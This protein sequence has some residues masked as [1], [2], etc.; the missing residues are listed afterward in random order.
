MKKK[1][2]NNSRPALRLTALVVCAMLWLSSAGNMACFATA[3]SN[4]SVYDEPAGTENAL[5]DDSLLFAEEISA[6]D[7]ADD[8]TNESAADFTDGPSDDNAALPDTPGGAEAQE[9][10][11]SQEDMFDEEA[12]LTDPEDEWILEEYAVGEEQVADEEGTDLLIEDPDAAKGESAETDDDSSQEGDL[13]S[14]DDPM[15]EEFVIDEPLVVE[16]TGNAGLLRGAK[17]LLGASSDASG[18]F[19]CYGD[20]LG[21][22]ARRIY[23]FRKQ[24]YVT[25]R[26]VGTLMYNTDGTPTDPRKFQCED[27]TFTKDT[28]ICTFTVPLNSE[29]Q[30]DKSSEE[31]LTAYSNILSICQSATDAYQYD[32][33]EM[34]WT[35]KAEY[36]V[37]YAYVASAYTLEDGTKVRDVY[38]KGLTYKALEAYPNAADTIAAYDQAVAQTAESIRSTSDFDGNGEVSDN[39][40][41]QGIHDYICERCWYDSAT[42]A[43]YKIN[44]DNGFVD[45]N[46]FTSAGVFLDSVSPGIVCEGYSRGFKVLCDYFGIRCACIGG[47]VTTSSDMGHMWNNV[48]LNGIWYMVDVTWDDSSSGWNWKL[49]LS[50]TDGKRTPKGYLSGPTSSQYISYTVG[51]STTRIKVSFTSVLFSLPQL[52]SDT[53]DYHILNPQQSSCTGYKEYVCGNDDAICYWVKDSS[54]A[55][56]P[57]HTWKSERTVDREP[58][59]EEA[60]IRAI[61]CE[62][63]NA[64]KR[65]SQE[66]IAAPGHDLN[67]V[68][69]KTATCEND[70]NEAY[71]KC[72]RCGKLFADENGLQETDSEA[73]T[74]HAPGHDL[75]FAEA[76]AAT[77]ENDGNEAYWRCERC[78]K[79]FADENG[80]QET[81]SETVT[82]HAPGHDLTFAEAKV[83]TCENDGN[84]AYWRCE[85][86]G[87]LFADENS[88][89][90]TDNESVKIPALGH[91]LKLV[92]AKAAT[93]E[94][95][96]IK[97][98]WKCERCGKLFA[99]ENG[100]QETDSEAVVIPALG[101][102]WDGGVITTPATSSKTGVRTYTC[103]R[104]GKT[105]TEE[106]P[107]DEKQEET[108]DPDA[109]N[110]KAA[111]E[112]EKIIK[113]KRDDT[114]LPGSAFGVLRA[115]VKK[116]RKTSVTLAWVECRN[117]SFY[118]VYGCRNL[119]G[120]SYKK[121]ATVTGLSFT[122]RGL[123]KG[124]NYKYLVVAVGGGKVLS[125]SKT[126][127]TA[128]TG[129]KYTNPKSVKVN[130]KRIRLKVRKTCKLKASAVLRSSKLV[131]K[132]FRKVSF[133]TS[134]PS[135]A[136]V[137]KKGKIRAVGKGKCTIWVYAQNGV[138]KAVKVT[139][140]E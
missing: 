90:E 74:I 91:D 52:G 83:A 109:E 25:G 80:L 77:C 42:L 55:D 122:H 64:V 129:G 3:S 68:E 38:V 75:T 139:V 72:E 63:C 96:G 120:R 73:V 60:G 17:R 115:R 101:H 62:T 131:M 53:H 97:A 49:F 23:D 132:K 137:S 107:A 102:D 31:Y 24:Y 89:Q 134:D 9:G 85:R 87:K 127:Y 81:D 76:K 98:Y 27:L 100:L 19:T 40:L 8:Y 34:F 15:T 6:N 117:A 13:S 11:F 18:S 86:C 10:L 1:N 28:T 58:T 82:I 50:P 33:P 5:Q 59:C 22:G 128:T 116:A 113:N 136:I 41:L 26:K 79:L 140:S 88:L 57:G 37:K 135:V 111:A 51:G 14:E 70:G 66:E 92:E 44:K 48:L 125:K 108:P 105:S 46:I 126:I 104:D 95:D 94:D 30:M 56:P 54:V 20:Q 45:Y 16:N 4:E 67:P 138:K 69:A 21:E 124:K 12:G 32:F 29:K 119:K 36:S 65:G 71:W 103:S 2:N 118:E 47:P 39:E 84:E 106:I 43:D 123:K 78:G 112:I 114:E 110:K 93:C 121:L 133:E 35:R 99:D 61:H 130:K 7:L